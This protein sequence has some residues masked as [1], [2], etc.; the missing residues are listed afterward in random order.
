MDATPAA[1]TPDG[2]FAADRW[3]FQPDPDETFRFDP[4]D[5][6]KWEVFLLDEDD[7]QPGPEEFLPH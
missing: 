4:E 7:S 2:E 5:D 1:M 6:R 3:D